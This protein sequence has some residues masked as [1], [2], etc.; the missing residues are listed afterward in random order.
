VLGLPVILSFSLCLILAFFIFGFTGNFA[1]ADSV[2]AKVQVLHDTINVR[3]GPDTS[4]QIIGH[5]YWGDILQAKAK[6]DSNWYQIDFHG[7][8]GWIAGWLVQV[9][10]YTPVA[11]HQSAP[12]ASR[13]LTLGII[14]TAERFLGRPYQYGSNGPY[15]FDCSGFVRYVF[16]LNGIDLP[17][18]ADEQARAGAKVPSPAPGDL[19]FFSAG[20]NGYM[21]HVGIYI[22]NNSFINAD[23]QGV[24]IKSLDD[25]WYQSRYAMTC[26]VT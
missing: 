8:T 20:R 15:S 21:T 11:S 14:S 25:P 9:Y 22:G 13:G 16:S 5:A 10:Q 12:V 23:D 19:V 6:S 7:Q 2:T 3:S 17:R 4:D 24:D 18:V 26:R 1:Y